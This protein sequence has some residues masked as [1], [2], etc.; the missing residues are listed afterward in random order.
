[1]KVIRS[2]N[3]DVPGVCFPFG[4]DIDFPKSLTIPDGRK[5]S[6]RDRLLKALRDFSFDGIVILDHTPALTGGS[7]AQTSYGVA[8]MKALLARANAEYKG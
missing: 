1:M 4:C 2:E 6:L 7:Y 5:N 8:Y 3:F